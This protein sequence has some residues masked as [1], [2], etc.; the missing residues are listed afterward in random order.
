MFFMEHYLIRTK[1]TMITIN[2]LKN[3]PSLTNSIVTVGTFDG[4]HLGHRAILNLMTKEAKKSGGSSVLVSFWPH[5]RM[6]LQ[7][8]DSSLKLLNT[9]EEKQELLG[10]T[11]LD[12]L[13]ILP[14]TKEFSRTPYLDFVKEILIS[15]LHVS[16]IVVGH[17]HHFG[18][19]REGNFS[20]LQLCARDY[21]FNLLEVEAEEL[22]G[23]TISSTEIRKAMEVG[24]TEKANQMLIEPYSVTGTV[25]HG[26]KIGRQLGFPTANIVVEESYKLMPS[27]GIYAV[28]VVTDLGEFEGMA[29]IGYRPTFDGTQKT[30]EVNIFDFD[31]DIYGQKIIVR[32]LAYLRKEVK[33]ANSK[34][35]IGQLK[36][37]ELDTNRFFANLK[38]KI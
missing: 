23:V 20:Q 4:V 26:D 37:D 32:F 35:L 19:D 29:S 5:P 16:T 15:K 14:F 30:F 11:G 17:D 12:Y 2:G 18:K 31:A 34:E 7:P 13:I 3:L 25:V 28:E 21:G 27:D 38:R 8:A 24:A 22:N 33:F 1:P 10:K 36:V 6:V 9:L